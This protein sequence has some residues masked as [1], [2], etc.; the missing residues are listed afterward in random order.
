MT[1]TLLYMRFRGSRHYRV[2]IRDLT[3]GTP[4][5]SWTRGV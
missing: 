1:S 4:R 3:H 2:A 5:A